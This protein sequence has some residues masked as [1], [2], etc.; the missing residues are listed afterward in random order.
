MNSKTIFAVLA[1][2]VLGTS[3]AYADKGIKNADTSGDGFVSLGELKAAHSARIEK[4]FNRMDTNADGLISEDEMAEA[5]QD[6]R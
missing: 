2:G 4:L 6:R 3:F 1:L 5:K